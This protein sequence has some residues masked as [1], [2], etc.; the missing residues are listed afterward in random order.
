MLTPGG[1]ELARRIST[2]LRWS[3]LP[4]VRPVGAV[5]ITAD[6]RASCGSSA[7]RRRTRPPEFRCGRRAATGGAAGLQAEATSHLRAPDATATL[8]LQPYRA[9]SDDGDHG[10]PRFS[11]DDWRRLISLR[12]S[13]RPRLLGTMYPRNA[14][15]ICL[16]PSSL[17]ERSLSGVSINSSVCLRE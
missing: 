14:L 16:M 11:S 17:I 5:H 2:S 4:C 6:N 3:V 15:A 8:M 1:S 9:Q 12:F 7:M 13:S 10:R